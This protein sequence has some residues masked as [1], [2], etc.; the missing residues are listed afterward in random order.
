VYFD[1]TFRAEKLLAYLEKAKAKH[2]AG[3]T[4]AFV[5]A[6]CIAIQDNPRMNQFT[7]GGRH[8]MRKGKWVSFSMKR[9]K[10][11]RKAKLSAVKLEIL[12]GETFAG[13]C[14]RMNGNVKVERSGERTQADV[15]F[16]VLGLMPQ[17]V[18]RGAIRLVKWLDLHG[19]LPA[20]FIKGDAMFTSAF[21][22][23]LGS[24]DMAPGYHHLYEYGTCPLFI[25]FGKVEQRPVVENG[26]VVVGQTIT[27]RFSY[28]E[29]IDDG[30]NASY[31]IE[32]LAEVLENPETWLGCLAEDGSDTQPL[33]PHGRTYTY[34]A[35]TENNQLAHD[36]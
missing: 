25:M 4:H 22:A 29:R 23:N 9:K 11:D 5:A 27:M 2:G 33:W 17:P 21:V 36:M 30:Q 1:R 15:E 24:V 35:V 32:A 8:Y 6:Y 31:G 14:A 3:L 7:V 20:W 13:L 16:D 10:R 12:P 28:D 34:A 26:Q 18:L 19:L